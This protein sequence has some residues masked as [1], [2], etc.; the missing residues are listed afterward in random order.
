MWTC[1]TCGRIFKKERQIH[2]CQK[3]TIGSHFINKERAKELFDYL[4]KRIEK[5]IGKCKVI[6]LPC[7][8][9]L[10]GNYDFLAALPK[11][12]KI[13]IRFALDRVLK[14]QRLKIAVLLSSK[15]FKNCFDIHSKQEIDHEFM[16][17]IK[18]SYFLK[19]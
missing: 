7:C 6:S 15:T 2:S 11:R 5:N 10:F 8:I 16:S 13:E 19:S 4:L 14:S 1:K 12:D 9:H 18:E 17:W 3:V